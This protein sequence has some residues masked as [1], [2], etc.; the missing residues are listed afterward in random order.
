[1][2]EK[3]LKE[4][5]QAEATA[6]EAKESSASREKALRAELEQ[7]HG[8]VESSADAMNRQ[9]EL[10]QA[11]R[12]QLVIDKSEAEA[13]LILAERTVNKPPPGRKPS[14][15]KKDKQRM[16]ML[17]QKVDSLA[18]SVASTEQGLAWMSQSSAEQEDAVSAN[19]EALKVM[20]STTQD[21]AT[22]SELERKNAALAESKNELKE[23]LAELKEELVIA[24]GSRSDKGGGTRSGGSGDRSAQLKAEKAAKLAEQQIKTLNTKV[25][26]LEDQLRI[27]KEKA[28]VASATSDKAGSREAERKFAKEIKDLEK[29]LTDKKKTDERN[30][31]LLDK[32]KADL[33]AKNEAFEEL[34]Q[35]VKKLRVAGS[36]ADKELA[37]LRA[38]AEKAAA[39]ADAKAAVESELAGLKADFH[40]LEKSYKDQVTLRKKYYNI[41]EDMK[42]KI[43]VYARCRPMAQYEIEKQ[44]KPSVSFPDEYTVDIQ[45]GNG[46][47]TRSFA[48]DCAFTPDSTQEETYEETSTLIQSA[49]DG[50]NVCVFAYG[51]TGSGK[52]FTMIGSESMP[53]LLP[54]A[55][56]DIYKRKEELADDYTINVKT[57]MLELYNDQI[58]DLLGT[59]K[60]SSGG[61][62]QDGLV[63]KKDK[64]GMVFC[65]GSTVVDCPT[66]ELLQE[67]W[68]KGESSR[69]VGFTKMNAG[70]SRSHLI[71]S[72]LIESIDLKTGNKSVGKLSLV[73]LAGSE[74]AGKTGATADRLKEAQS[75]N[76][77]LSALGD[78]ISAL[79]AGAE[80]IPYRNNK[81]TMLMSDSL[82]GNAKT[83][84]YVNISPADYN[85]DETLTSLAYAARVKMITNDAN[86]NQESKEVA[87][88]K[89]QIKALQAGRTVADETTD[90]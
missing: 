43:R 12:D 47:G 39:T 87:R 57:Y 27:E 66:L 81:L 68:K 90:I 86:K 3:V 2:L 33:A 48:Y 46:K 25:S 67:C 59:H 85:T 10:L 42:G 35:E 49:L 9:K 45:M 24:Q 44:C 1:M 11:A 31:K 74:R 15:K 75:I 53:G 70:S 16:Q 63:V 19:S 28:A 34:Q 61:G 18:T 89:E 52:T 21:A 40:A 20:Q 6:S 65:P 84:M 14:E 80:F 32:L 77:S 72:I 22:I 60:K 38:V 4:A 88:L 69:H 55:M 79:S 51:Q 83:L 29:K 73:D 76:K 5:K 26:R 13:E 64:N 56:I 82:G 50:Y 71:I 37:E 30:T 62:K 8:F 54:R 58:L 78:V 23:Q 36:G 41:I 7:L 17:K